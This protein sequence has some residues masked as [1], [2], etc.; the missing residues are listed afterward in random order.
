[1]NLFRT[2]VRALYERLDLRLLLLPE[3]APRLGVIRAQQLVELRVERSK[4]REYARR[5][6]PAG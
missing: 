1:M 6:Q 3:G 2:S 4:D 5:G